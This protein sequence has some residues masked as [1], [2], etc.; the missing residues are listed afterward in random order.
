MTKATLQ[1]QIAICAQVLP[2]GEGS[3]APEW[4]HLLP[5]GEIATADRRGPYHVT[6]LD[7]LVANSMRDGVDLLIDQDHATDLAAPKGDPAPARGWITELQARADGIWGRV[8]WT[9]EGRGL[10][11]SRA[12]RALS[13]VLLHDKAKRVSRIL[14]ASLVNQPNLRGLVALNMETDDMS[15]Q[16]RLAELLGLGA[17]ATETAIQSA[18]QALADVDAPA[19]QSQLAEIGT[20]LGVKD[21][22]DIVA[23]AQAAGKPGD[24]AE[25]IVALQ[26]SVTAL[27]SEVVEQAKTIKTLTENT[28]R[29]AAEAFVDGEIKR[30]R[31]G[32]KPLRDHYVSMHM[33]D[34]ARVEKEIGAL[35]ILSGTT[36]TTPPPEAKDGEISLNA[37]QVAAAKLL[38]VPLDDYKAT[39]KEELQ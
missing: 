23:A 18:V 9:G 28:T 11:V 26:A 17:D 1:K 27:Q 15:F 25:T 16:E 30:G 13:P 7:Q 10:V 24:D 36:I 20:A 8:E 19:L 21:G 39:L 5:A 4:V 12:Y 6:D 32:V 22:G 31:V 35:P 34:A 14:R 33:Q 29:A 38:G 3:D 37:E 2:A